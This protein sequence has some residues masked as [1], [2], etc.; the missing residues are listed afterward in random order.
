MID[1]CERITRVTTNSDP[2][3]SP[4]PEWPARS[5]VAKGARAPTGARVTLEFTRSAPVTAGQEVRL[6]YDF[7]GNGHFVD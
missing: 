4:W 7:M 2:I 1:I 6:R 5:R 3:S